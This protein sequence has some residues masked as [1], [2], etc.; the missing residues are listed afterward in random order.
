MYPFYLDPNTI[1]Y[2]PESRLYT[3][4]N[5]KRLGSRKRIKEQVAIYNKVIGFKPE[6]ETYW[7]PFK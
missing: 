4:K 1:I 2:I 5:I 7:N 3:P 6:N